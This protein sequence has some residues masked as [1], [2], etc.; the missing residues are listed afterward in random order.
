MLEDVL[1]WVVVIIGATVMKFTDFYLLDPLLSIGVALF[2]LINAVRNLTEI[3]DIF[4]LKTPHGIS[5]PEIKEHLLEIEGVT[6]VHHIHLWS[7]DGHNTYTTMHIVISGDAHSIK[8]SVRDE[9]AEHGIVHAT[10]ETENAYEHCH[11]KE[12]HVK[13]SSHHGHHHHHHH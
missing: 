2:I 11:E 1:G 4:L 9:L 7:I 13:A 3:L 10:L 8:H 12:C 5:V 6:D